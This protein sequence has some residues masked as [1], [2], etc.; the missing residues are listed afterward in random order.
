MECLIDLKFADL[1]RTEFLTICPCS[2]KCP[3]YILN[4][5]STLHSHWSNFYL[6][7]RRC[8][9]TLFLRYIGCLHAVLHRH[10]VV[11]GRPEKGC[12]RLSACFVTAL[13]NNKLVQLRNITRTLLAKYCIG[14]QNKKKSSNPRNQFKFKLTLLKGPQYFIRERNI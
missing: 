5:T 13:R 10:N 2:K 14:K 12:F 4:Q 6:S 7:S 8:K 9:T 1:R 3:V 11:L